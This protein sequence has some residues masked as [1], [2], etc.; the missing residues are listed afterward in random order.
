MLEIKHSKTVLL[1][2]AAEW[3]SEID[4]ARAQAALEQAKAVLSEQTLRIES[5]MA[6]EQLLRAQ[7]R[8]L[9]AKSP[10]A[11]SIAAKKVDGR[12]IAA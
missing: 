12:V 2:E 5:A 8:L 1:V 3:P 6:K 7:T 10:E 11:A 9:V 4:T